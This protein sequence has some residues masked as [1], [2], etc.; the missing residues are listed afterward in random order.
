M[1]YELADIRHNFYTGEFNATT[2]E[3]GLSIKGTIQN[4]FLVGHVFHDGF[5]KIGPIEVNRD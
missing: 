2:K 5:G 4:G 3:E 1:E